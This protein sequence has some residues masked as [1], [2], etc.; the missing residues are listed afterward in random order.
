MKKSLV[1]IWG[2]L[3]ALSIGMPYAAQAQTAEAADPLAACLSR[4]VTTSDRLL[5]AKWIFSTMSRHPE[6]QDLASVPEAKRDAINKDTAA[7]MMR[8]LTKTCAA[9][10][11]ASVRDNGAESISTAFGVLG[12]QAMEELMGHPQVDA[13]LNKLVEYID[14]DALLEAMVGKE[15]AKAN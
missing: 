3:L 4:S 2:A 8:L 10:T 15:E 9:E 13:E 14:G 7:L 1:A 5:L 6:V 12:E 11:R